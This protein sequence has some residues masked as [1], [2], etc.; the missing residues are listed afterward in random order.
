M[1]NYFYFSFKKYCISLMCSFYFYSFTMKNLF[2]LIV[3]GCLFAWLFFLFKEDAKTAYTLH[4][5]TLPVA[6][7][8]G[9][10]EGLQQTVEQFGSLA[11]FGLGIIMALLFGLVWIVLKWCGVPNRR[12]TI[13]ILFLMYILLA[14]L[15]Y[16]LVY[17][18]E[19]N[20]ILSSLVVYYAWKPL[21]YASIGVIVIL[22]IWSFRSKMKNNRSLVLIGWISL[23]SFVLS[24]CTLLGDMTYF[25]CRFVQDW[26]QAAHCYQEA[27]VQ[28]N[29]ET[30]CNKAPQWD[31]FKSMWSN[32]PQDKCYF[33]V[34]ENKRDPEVCKKIKWWMLSYSVEECFNQ[35]LDSATKEINNKLTQHEE[36]KQLSDSELQKIQQQLQTYTTLTENMSSMTKNMHDMNKALIQNIK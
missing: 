5:T 26:K 25:S 8:F 35:V 10:W 11:W 31:E 9:G 4:L 32:P 28:K 22:I 21:L 20:S 27:A 3:F 30:I 7:S 23:S 13:I 6:Q 12:N 34:A 17:L 15:G 16:E 33:M 24:W 1:S 19:T 18:E 36:G 2:F 14:I 29:D